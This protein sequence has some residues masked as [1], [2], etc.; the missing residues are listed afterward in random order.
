[1]VYD[2]IGGREMAYRVN[3]AAGWQEFKLYRA[4][5]ESAD[6]RITFELTGCGSVAIDEVTVRTVDLN[7]DVGSPPT[8]PDSPAATTGQYPAESIKK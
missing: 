7:L 2:S 1:M 4:A 5:G 8:M 6:L 3:H